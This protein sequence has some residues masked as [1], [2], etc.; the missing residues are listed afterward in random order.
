[1]SRVACLVAK[2]WLYICILSG[3]LIY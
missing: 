2:S 1:M 3:V